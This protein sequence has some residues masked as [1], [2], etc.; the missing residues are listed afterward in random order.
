MIN[1]KLKK[2]LLGSMLLC[3]ATATAE[4]KQFGSLVDCWTA[5][6]GKPYEGSSAK[7]KQD[8]H[9]VHV[10][11]FTDK[12]RSD[13][14]T[15]LGKDKFLVFN[16]DGAQLLTPTSNRTPHPEYGDNGMNKYQM[17]LVPPG[18]TN[19]MQ[20]GY[21]TSLKGNDDTAGWYGAP[22]WT[23]ERDDLYAKFEKD[24]VKP[25]DFTKARDVMRMVIKGKAEKDEAGLE[26]TKEGLNFFV[27][28]D[29]HSTE[30]GRGTH[31]LP[32]GQVNAKRL[33]SEKQRVEKA[34]SLSSACSELGD[35]TIKQAGLKKKATLQELKDFLDT[36]GTQ[37][38][39]Q[40]QGDRNSTRSVR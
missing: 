29:S 34:I 6:D 7:L 16:R 9:L 35:K 23:K 39:G 11:R 8:F 28:A 17:T 20:V 13:S 5:M 37:P 2:L 36:I 3:S 12:S 27:K 24:P 19:K 10:L 18:E 14:E 25:M 33:T 40:Q 38:A 31:S 15:V 30:Q 22:G 21:F 32:N 26:K 4:N 1:K